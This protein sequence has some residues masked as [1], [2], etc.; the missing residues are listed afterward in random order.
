MAS[1]SKSVKKIDHE[2]KISGHEMYT[3][4]YKTTS[5]G[6][7]ILSGRLL[8]SPVAKGIL[9]N[10]VVPD[11]PEGYYY[12]SAKDAP[13]NVSYYPFNDVP[14][15]IPKE[16]QERMLYSTP[17][18]AD[19]ELE[20]AGQP[21]GLIAGPDDKVVRELLRKCRVEYDELKPVVHM[22]DS[23]EEL[24]HLERT[25]GNPDLAFL[26]ADYVYDETFRTGRQYQAYIE[27]QSIIAEP[28]GGKSVFVHGAMQC[29]FVLRGSVAC[30]LDC[31]TSLVRVRQEATGGAFGGKEDFPSLLGPQ[32]AVAAVATGEPVRIILD[33]SEDL[34]FAYKRHP[35]RTRVRIAVRDGKI[36]AM[37]INC[38][39][40]A[41][42]YQSSSG[43]VLTRH[44]CT[45]PGVYSIDSL[46]VF[47]RAIKT[48]TPPCGAFRGFGVPQAI[49][50]V[51]MAMSHLARELG[52]D[53]IEFKREYFAK[54]GA[55]MP[56]GGEYFYDVPLL[57]MLD[58]AD[59]S[60][61][62]Y[63]KH[64]LYS[65]ES[66][67]RIRYGI[68]IAFTQHG[69]P[70][71]GN[72]EW[73]FIKA[74]VR[75]H[76]KAD[77]SIEIFTGQVDM[78]QGIRTALSKI[79]SEAL[80]IPLE[81]VSCGYPD[82]SLSSDTGPTAASRSI[83]VIGKTIVRAAEELKKNWIEGENQEAT[84]EYGKPEHDTT[85]DDEAFFGVQYEDYSWQISVV[86]VAVDT[87]TG[88]IEIIS[89]HSVINVG[90]PIDEVILRGQMEGGLL[91]ALGYSAYEKMVFGENGK[92]F[93][94]G[95]PDYHMPTSADVKNLSVE[96]LNDEYPEGPFGAKGAG[97]LPL[98]GVS[99][100]YLLAIE[101]A[102]GKYKP[103]MLNSIPFT[104]EDAL[105]ASVKGGSVRG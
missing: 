12:V 8:R 103:L 25:R 13:R 49:F 58:M 4:D 74:K 67:G 90:T 56:T 92:I 24:F 71:A 16:E 99:A 1:I 101:Q 17:L 35:S 27:T 31:D 82:T 32:A 29:P 79:A 10:V 42:A 22:D 75:L 23:N 55:K 65:K 63:K 80:G 104:A 60:T 26:T 36:T 48:N 34:Q 81:R 91:Q 28:L 39:L 102:L 30:A 18:F 41:G 70:L 59:A 3:G 57:K 50:A 69:F 45:F 72:V 9:R 98:S 14:A 95:F 6:R 5:D 20:Y 77:G 97:E 62:Y 19:H 83:H 51:E 85:F 61:S 52:R 78:G 53:E 21:I 88:N 93:N 2:S 33:R 100:A 40:D 68:G 94:T 43:D 46:H 66:S 64:E 105:T 47:G 38:A 84:A 37:D 86:E 54:K 11:L 96:F 15:S 89:A 44:F 7:I 76:K 87:L 73:K